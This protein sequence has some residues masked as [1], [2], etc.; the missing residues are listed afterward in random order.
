MNRDELLKGLTKEQIEK[1]QA[2]KTQEE[3][4]AL[5]KEEGIELNEEQL[6]Y[7]SGGGCSKEQ[8]TFMCPNCCGT[9]VDARYDMFMRNSEGGYVC[10]CR[11]CGAR[12]ESD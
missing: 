12:F 6:Q 7:V 4:L 3:L 11:D 10:I 2:C 1:A 8:P 5:A 9:N